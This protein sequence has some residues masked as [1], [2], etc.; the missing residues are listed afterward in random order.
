MTINAACHCAES[1][2][3]YKGGKSLLKTRRVLIL[4]LTSITL[5]TFALSRA[6]RTPLG[7][8]ACKKLEHTSHLEKPN[9]FLEAENA[10]AKV[11]AK[12]MIDTWVAV[13][14]L[15]LSH[16]IMGV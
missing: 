10:P 2:L 9:T 7:A 8:F 5:P 14:E 13:K 15:K 4:S 3:D 1:E 12:R 16:Y 11:L 6:L